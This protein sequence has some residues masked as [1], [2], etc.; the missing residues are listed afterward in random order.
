MGISATQLATVMMVLQQVGTIILAYMTIGYLPEVCIEGVH[1]L[2]STL[3]SVLDPGQPVASITAQG[4][5]MGEVRYLVQDMRVV[6]WFIACN[7]AA[8]VGAWG[9]LRLW[10]DPPSLAG[11]I[12]GCLVLVLS[13]LALVMLHETWHRLVSG[14]VL[15]LVIQVGGWW[16]WIGTNIPS[17]RIS[18]IREVWASVKQGKPFDP[19]RYMCLKKGVFVGLDE[20]ERA[21]YVPLK[22]FRRHWEI[23]GQT[24]AGKGLGACTLLDQAAQLGECVVILDPKGD[25]F[26]PSVMAASAQC[27]G[28]PFTLIDLR[29][30]Q[31]P[32][33]NLL[34]G[35]TPQDIEEM[36]IQVFDLTEKGDNADIYRIQD[37]A[38]ARLIAGSGACSFPELYDKAAQMLDQSKT[39]RLYEALRELA[40]LPAIQTAAGIDLSEIV[41]R[42]GILYVTGST[43]YEPVVRLQKAI[44]LRVLQIL[45]KRGQ[46]KE[47]IWTALFLDEFK[48]LLSPA[49]LQALGVIA[50]RRCHLLLAHQSL[51]DLRDT[52]LPAAAVEGAVLVN[53][54]LKL[55]FRTNDPDTATWEARVCGTVPVHTEVTQK[56]IFKFH[57]AEGSWRE[58]ARPIFDENILQSL[59]PFCAI[60]VGAGVPRKVRFGFLPVGE[61]PTPV[62]A[63]IQ[64]P[65]NQELI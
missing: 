7:V 47:G 6:M 64:S 29:E 34:A 4:I 58:S 30:G 31:P 37:R 21:V 25:T 27:A 32:Q 51:G 35:C 43:R 54:A 22:E 41:G 1:G 49:A 45:D 38:A 40:F 15:S 2:V 17:G 16:N 61:R 26:M 59:P 44:L 46:E 55:L 39:R 28:V 42:P 24:R 63:P 33:L 57:N 12:F 36:L 9:V 62:P 53:C 11:R 8:F 5:V 65:T 10:T 3:F 52:T 19:T 14:Y 48:Y 56:T 20:K 23:I 50:D 60:L 18:D 13:P